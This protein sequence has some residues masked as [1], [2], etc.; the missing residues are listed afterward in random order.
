MTELTGKVAFVTGGAQGIGEAISKRLAEDGFA[1]AVADLN[2]TNANKV[3]KDIND[4]GGK[5]VGIQ[6]DVSDY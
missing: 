3:A 2:E 5:A 4:A 6:V 1:V